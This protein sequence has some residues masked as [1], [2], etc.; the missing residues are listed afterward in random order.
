LVDKKL[1]EYGPEWIMATTDESRYRLSP[2]FGRIWAKKGSKPICMTNGLTEKVN[3]FGIYDQE[4]RF[5]HMYAERQ[6]SDSFI[7][8]LKF[9]LQI[10]SHTI[11][12]L[13]RASWHK[14][15]KTTKFLEENSGRIQ[16]VFLPPCTPEANPTEECWK[17]TRKN[18]TT[19]RY[20]NSKKDMEKELTEFFDTREFNHSLLSYLGL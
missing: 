7:E 8:F 20:F 10:Y 9:I 15:K 11:L 5:N 13:D 12:I 14:S 16:P 19:N 3:V 2:I 17:Q 6:N 18:V 4:K 1:Q